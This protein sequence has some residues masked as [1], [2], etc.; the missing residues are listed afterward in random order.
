MVVELER[1]G[2]REDFAQQSAGKVPQITRPHP[3][4]AITLGELTEDGVYPVAKPTE[5]GTLFRGR[6]SLLGRIWGQKLYA[7]AG[8][9][10]S[11]LW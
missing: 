4:Y 6:V 3:L 1:Y 11:G 5:E 7:H 10:F 2:V 8:Q 9:L